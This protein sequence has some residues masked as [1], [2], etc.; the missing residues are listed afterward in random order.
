[1]KDL[2]MKDTINFYETLDSKI[3]PNFGLDDLDEFPIPVENQEHIP[4]SI[5]EIGGIYN[6][7]SENIQKRILESELIKISGYP[8]LYFSKKST[9]EELK[10]TTILEDRLYENAIVPSYIENYEEYPYE[11]EIHL[12]Q[13][14]EDIPEVVRKIITTQGFIHEL[15]HV[16][17]DHFYGL[18]S[19]LKYNDELKNRKELLEIFEDL[20]ENLP[21]ISNYS[22]VYRDENGKYKNLGDDKHSTGIRE[23]FCETLAAYKLGFVYS[24]DKKRQLDPFYD[25]P[26]VK[27]FIE[28]F[29]DAELL[30]DESE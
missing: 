27:E 17:F 22:S 15:G 20:T 23:E 8:Q 21:A 29:L 9:P 25:R 1:M 2:D 12:Y 3:I 30:V 18:D 10:V 24:S 7:F 16:L 6:S 5:K 26:K 28:N 14:P 4:L 19:E 11:R 13:L